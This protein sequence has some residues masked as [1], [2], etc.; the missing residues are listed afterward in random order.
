MPRAAPV[1]M[2]AR[3]RRSIWF[4]ARLIA[5]L[6]LR[7]VPEGEAP[8]DPGEQPGQQQTEQRQHHEPGIGFLDEKGALRAQD[9]IAETAAAR[10]HLGRD[11]EDEAET[12][13]H[14]HAGEDIG[15]ARRQQNPA[16]DRERAVAERAR[17]VD[18]RRLDRAHA[19]QRVDEHG[20]KATESDDGDLHLGAE[21]EE[22]DHHRQ[23]RRLGQG[24]QQ[25]GER[26]EKVENRARVPHEDAERDRSDTADAIADEEEE[27]RLRERRKE[28]ARGNEAPE[29]RE[30]GAWR[31][32]ESRID[33]AAARGEFEAKQQDDRYGAAGDDDAEALADLT[34]G[35]PRDSRA[36]GG[37]AREIPAIPAFRSRGAAAAAWSRL[38]RRSSTAAASAPRRDRRERSP[39][40]RHALRARR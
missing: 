40:R 26:L 9:R 22:K 39:R 35:A 27:D 33:E 14:A 32:Q 21:A 11:H 30:N 17:G 8:L 31:W 10:D 34:H 28:A 5:L 1:T 23:E 24:P 19:L 37:A 16:P 29:C 20:E 15:R 13:A 38:L 3:P 2:A 4:M 25:L 7:R 36:A 18:H 6:G 12:E